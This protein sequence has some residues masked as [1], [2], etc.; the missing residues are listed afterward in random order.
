MRIVIAL[1]AASALALSACADNEPVDPNADTNIDLPTV[2]D[3]NA[4]ANSAANSAGAMPAMNFVGGDGQMLGSLSVADTPAGVSLTLAGTG[5]PAGI[6]GLHLHAVGK[7]D[8]PKFESAGSH[9][10]PENKMHGTENPQ[11]PH[12]GDLPNATV[13]ADGSLAQVL[14]IQG[15]TLAQLQDGDGTAL[16]VHA[17]PD[18]NK[19]DPSGNSGDRIACAVIAPAS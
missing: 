10:N 18:D 7:C 15:V 8:G 12:K 2:N 5:M 11:G 19:T 6:H 17:S 4:T 1:T 14:T 9:W 16:V 13:A 3:M